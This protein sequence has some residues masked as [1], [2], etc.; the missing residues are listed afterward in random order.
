M[1]SSIRQCTLDEGE[2]YY[3]DGGVNAGATVTSD[4]PVLVE[5]MTGD[6]ASQIEGRWFE[7]LPTAFWADIYITP[8][9]TSGGLP[10]DVLLYN[11]ND[12]SIDVDIT[13]NGGA[14]GTITIPANS[15][16]RFRMPA[17][18]GARFASTAGETFGAISTIDYDDSAHDGGFA[19][20]PERLLTTRIVIGWAPGSSDG[21]A[22]GSPIWITAPASTRIYID[23][24]NAIPGTLTDPNGDAYDVHF[25]VNAFDEI[26]VYDPDFDQTGLV[27]YTLDDTLLSAAWGQDPATATPFNPFLDLGTSIFP[28]TALSV[29]KSASLV[30]DVNGNGLVEPGDQLEYLISVADAGNLALLN[31]VVTDTVPTN[32]SYVV[33]STTVDAVSVAD[34]AVPPA[35]TEFPLD[36]SGHALGTVNP[37]QTVLVRFRVLIDAGLLPS[38]TLVLNEVAVTANNTSGTAAVETPVVVPDLSITKSSSVVGLVRG[39]DTITYTIDIAN[40]GSLTHSSLSVED[41]TPAGTSWVSTTVTGPVVSASGNVRDE[42]N[43]A[44]WSLNNGSFA[45]SGDWFETDSGGQDP[46]GGDIQI[47]TNQSD[48]RLRIKDND[49]AIERTADLSAFNSASLSYSFRRVN[50]DSVNDW[51]AVYVDDGTSRIELARYTGEFVT[52][53][54]GYTT[55]IHDV[56]P[57]VASGALVVSFE[58]SSSLGNNDVVY[59]DD[60]DISGETRTIQTYPGSAPS[61]IVSGADLRP[62]ESMS[63]DVVVTLDDP[64]A[65]G[66]TSVDNVATVFSN[67]ETAGQSAAATNPLERRNDLVLTKTAAPD[68]VWPASRSATPSPSPT[69]GPTYQPTA[70]WSTPF[71]PIRRSPPLLQPRD[72]VPRW[73]AW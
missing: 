61:T 7:L 5:L 37:G 52:S 23:Y 19:V 69:T 1:G 34:D 39:G 40:T 51:V 68:P 8:V 65:P 3:V 60:V 27:G 50:L 29:T 18:S 30:V 6:D 33:G 24:G 44:S 54:A 36:E 57:Y 64:V 12:S 35:A 41:P 53:D 21:S 67:V 48:T 71:P 4:E 26:R 31:V 16:T 10:T 13:D 46:S 17:N 73:A 45:W 47:V 63:I 28:F 56:S 42:F 58:S 43:S 59:F 72:H 62:G 15:S 32:T 70:S 25:D 66:V 14:A 2:S 49:R 11:P 20:V 38:V 22:N 55:V 9:G